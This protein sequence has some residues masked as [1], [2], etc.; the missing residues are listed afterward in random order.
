MLTDE[1]VGRGKLV[2][3]L[4]GEHHVS[5]HKWIQLKHKDSDE[6]DAGSLQV[7]VETLDAYDASNVSARVGKLILR[8]EF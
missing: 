3:D 5:L 6:T 4:D 2:L 1:T 7:K 8:A